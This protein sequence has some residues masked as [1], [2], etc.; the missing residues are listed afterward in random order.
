[1]ASDQP[2]LE[3]EGPE[4][5]YCPV[6]GLSCGQKGPFDVRGHRVTDNGITQKLWLV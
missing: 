1:M 4:N 2:S 3:G 6:G 5:K